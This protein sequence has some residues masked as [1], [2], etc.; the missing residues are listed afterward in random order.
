VHAAGIYGGPGHEV[1]AADYVVSSYVPTISALI[2]AR[3]QWDRLAITKISAALICE[4][5]EGLRYLPHVMHEVQVIRECFTDAGAQ[6]LNTST[7]QATVSE[8]Q[9]LLKGSV[10]QVLHLACHGVQ[11]ADALQSSFTLKDGNLSIERIMELNLPHAVMAYLS[12][13]HTA[14]GSQDQPDQSVHLAASMLF[15]GFRSV[16]GT[17]W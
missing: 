13:C 3:N 16:I 1:C 7:P 6:V 15:C 5:S 4:P 11:E 8:L 17:M 2:K 9:A 12:A 10:T 14:K